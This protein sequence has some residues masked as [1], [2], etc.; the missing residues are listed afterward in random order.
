MNERKTA[1]EKHQPGS[2]DHL[3]IFN[4][5]FEYPVCFT[6][7]VFDPAND[8]LARTIDRLDEGRLHRCCVFV[9]AG[10]AAAQDDLPA[11]IQQYFHAHR[12]TLELAV[13]PQS[14][15]GGKR[16][17]TD[18]QAVRNVLTTIGN[19]HLD[20]QSFVLA[21]GGGSCLDMLGFAA[22]IVHR[23]LR[24]VR[25]PS[26]TLGQNDAGIGVKNGMDEHGQKNFIGT[27][28][29]PFAV[30][31]DASLPTSCDQE[32]WIAGVAEAIK[33]AMIKDAAFFE[34][35]SQLAGAMRMRDSQAMQQVVRRC[36]ELHLEHIRTGGD[37]FEFGSARPL[38]F[39][40][41]AAH[42]LEML[43][44][45]QLGH[46][47]A[48]ALGICVDSYCAMRSSLLGEAEFLSV[49]ETIAAAGLPTWDDLL[50]R[51][52][53]EGK[54]EILGGLDDFREHLGGTLTITLPDGIGGKTEVH[55]L[56]AAD[57][58]DAVEY[59]QYRHRK[60]TETPDA[61]RP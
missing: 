36:A 31:N 58:E 18:W 7:N 22:S 51:R 55:H 12:K 16:A 6:R 61:D 19:A 38:D 15:P 50:G 52:K 14:V 28:A 44:G 8:C 23:G 39:G 40:H 45:Y 24:L 48:V 47:Q 54:L 5:A 11:R 13:P 41:W 57:V 34:M 35:I 26:T 4:V 42:K 21:V 46:G 3:Q 20:R 37:P 60:D 27:F 59:L 49:L 17:K 29:P 33:V 32:T 53:R 2:T 30:I 10:L 25:I 56:N 9:D 43:S 1:W